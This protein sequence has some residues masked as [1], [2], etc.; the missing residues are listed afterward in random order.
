MHISLMQRP[1]DLMLYA[2]ELSP[3]MSLLIMDPFGSHVVRALLL[4][5]A[6]GV[7]SAGT[8]SQGPSGKPTFALRSKK[9]ATYKARQGSMK[10]VFA[11]FGEQSQATTSRRV[12]KEFRKA[13]FDI[14]SALR[15]QLDGNEVRAMAAH[16]VASPVLQVC[17]NWAF[18]MFEISI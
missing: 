14:V 16:T 5:L 9:S 10:S 13:A 6:P 3:T 1:W 2:Q 12:P 7:F 15:N 17:F 8:D 11:E 4:L 18:Q